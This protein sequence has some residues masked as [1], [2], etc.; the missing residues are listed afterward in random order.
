VLSCA[1]GSAAQLLHL[2]KVK[3]AIA[4][5]CLDIVCQG[6]PNLASCHLIDAV[7]REGGYDIQIPVLHGILYLRQAADGPAQWAGQQ[8]AHSTFTGQRAHLVK[9]IG[10]CVVQHC[11]VQLPLS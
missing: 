4:Q 11:D 7:L 8:E 5:A 3:G 2:L 1:C 10:V 6:R 9:Q